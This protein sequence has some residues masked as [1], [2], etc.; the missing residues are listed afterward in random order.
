MGNA[1]ASGVVTNMRR[2][3][4]FTTT[5]LPLLCPSLLLFCAGCSGVIV[6]TQDAALGDLSVIVW[7]F[8]HHTEVALELV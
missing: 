1:K 5:R 7:Y 6:Q 2:M 3:M 8:Y 4:K